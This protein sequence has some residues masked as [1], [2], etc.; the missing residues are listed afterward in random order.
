MCWVGCLRSFQLSCEAF[1]FFY[2]LSDSKFSMQS[3]SIGDMYQ[4]PS[5][6][7][8]N[9]ELDVENDELDI[10]KLMKDVEYIGKHL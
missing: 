5:R 4:K 1:F 10:R 2:L 6:K 3:G 7:P 9:Q 8:I